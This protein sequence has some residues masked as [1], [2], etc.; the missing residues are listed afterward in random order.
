MYRFIGWISLSLSCTLGAASLHAEPTQ[1]SHDL[2]AILMR[3]LDRAKI[4]EHNYEEFKQ[5]YYYRNIRIRE[6]FDGKGRVT[7]QK[8]RNRQNSPDPVAQSGRAALDPTDDKVPLDSLDD[9]AVAERLTSGRAFSRNDFKVDPAMLNRFDF[10]LV[11]RDFIEGRPM[12][13][14]EF[15][16]SPRQPSARSL[17]DRLI[18]RAA[19]RFWVDEQEWAVARAELRL[20][21]PVSVLGGV[22][23]VLRSFNYELLRERSP[24][25]MWY[26]SQVDW[27][28]EG[29]QFLVN[30]V[31]V[32][33]EHKEDVRC[34][35]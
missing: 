16:P 14:I 8:V 6:E 3:V 25:G 34:I 2:N 24:E 17:K 26:I 32:H 10:T 23:G 22:V 21:E 4:E 7:R 35:R 12:F 13:V 30:K 18:N 27:Q 31:V 33:H 11:G 1:T 29:R 28:L 5:R 9:R 15:S 19:G 20:S